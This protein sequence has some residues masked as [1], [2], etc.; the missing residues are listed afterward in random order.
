MAH[1]LD[2]Y[3]DFVTKGLFQVFKDNNPIRFIE[4]DDSENIDSDVRN[5]ALLY[6]GGKN[7]DKIYFGKRIIYDE[8]HAHYMYPNQARLRNM[9]Y[10]FTIHYDVDVEFKKDVLE[11][12]DRMEKNIAMILEKLNMGIDDD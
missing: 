7:G 5:E 2:S 10:G 9:T 12:L 6:L 1:H 4:R 11:R 8:S 3:N